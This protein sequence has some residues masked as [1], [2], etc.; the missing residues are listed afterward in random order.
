MGN[1]SFVSLRELRTS[2]AKISNM[3]SDDGKIIVT[4]NG[5]PKAIMLHVT[6]SNFED[7]LAAINQVKLMRT[8]SNI[9]IAA[10][11]S[12]ASKMTLDEINEEIRAARI[13]RRMRADND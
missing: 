1:M 8:I 10:Q 13:D 6:E 7:T 5:K 4:S 2:T 9:R 12:G 11:R 3:L